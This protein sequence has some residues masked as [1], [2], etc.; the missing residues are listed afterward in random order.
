M[1]ET[2]TLVEETYIMH[3]EVET[4]SKTYLCLLL[5]TLQRKTEIQ[6]TLFL[7]M[8]KI[9]CPELKGYF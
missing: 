5:I 8:C 3:K 2:E 7:I 6:E 9:Q 4:L 1:M